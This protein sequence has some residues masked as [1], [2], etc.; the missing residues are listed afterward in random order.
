MKA[1]SD[2]RQYIVDSEPP[3][4][5]SSVIISGYMVLQ[6]TRE[7]SVNSN[8]PSGGSD[9]IAAYSEPTLS[10]T[11]SFEKVPVAPLLSAVL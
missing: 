3:I 11:S 8:S 1:L 6:S 4:S 5:V 10:G 7:I 2:Y 9:T